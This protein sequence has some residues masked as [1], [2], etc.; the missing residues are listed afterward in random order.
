MQH[1]RRLGLALSAL[2]TVGAVA[3][4][5]ALG[6]PEFTLGAFPNEF[7][8]TSG[9]AKFELGGGLVLQCKK[10]NIEG[11]I[12]S[13]KAG[14]F[15]LDFKECSVASLGGTCK[16]AATE[17]LVQLEGEFRLVLINEE[18]VVGLL[19]LDPPELHVVCEKT[20]FGTL[21]FQAR[22]AFFGRITPTSTLTTKYEFSFKRRLNEKGE[23][24]KG[25]PQY[26]KCVAPAES[27]EG[28]LYLFEVLRGGSEVFEYAS[29][30]TKET[31]ITTKKEVKIKE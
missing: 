11:S 18:K 25:V 6:A 5:A 12:T 17:G 16:S 3:A 30:E 31:K 13:A 19:F 1:L 24:E 29:L 14:T 20:L 23:P 8:G 28:K 21:L 27:C 2:L 15:K 9:E 10:A 22:G 26:S 7:S 4:A